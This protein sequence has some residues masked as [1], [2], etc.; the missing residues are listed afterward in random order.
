MQASCRELRQLLP[1]YVQGLCSEE[2]RRAVEEH[3]R[4]CEE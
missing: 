1:H 3:V 2:E 4:G